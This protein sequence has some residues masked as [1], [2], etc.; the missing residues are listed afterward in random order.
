LPRFEKGPPFRRKEGIRK[1]FRVKGKGSCFSEKR[2]LGLE[3][4]SSR[5]VKSAKKKKIPDIFEKGAKL[6]T[7]GRT[8]GGE[9]AERG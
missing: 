8:K 6:T 1:N 5:G 2:E 3:R 9:K 4:D 7:S